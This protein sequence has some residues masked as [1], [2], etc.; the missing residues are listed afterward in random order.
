MNNDSDLNDY[1]M[2]MKSIALF[3]T[4]QNTPDK[5]TCDCERNYG[6]DCLY[7]D[8]YREEGCT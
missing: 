2:E 5:Y 7:P 8:K 6:R 4:E 3:R 1:D